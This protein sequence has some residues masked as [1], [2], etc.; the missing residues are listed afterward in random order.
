MSTTSVY[1]TYRATLKKARSAAS[2]GRT[3]ERKQRALKVA[4]DRHHLPISQVKQIVRDM[5]AV[6]N[7]THEHTAEYQAKLDFQI[8]AR[9]LKKEANGA[10]QSSFHSEYTDEQR[11]EHEE[12]VP[13]DTLTPEI[14]VHPYE[15]E[16]YGNAV[17]VFVC[18]MCYDV[19]TEDV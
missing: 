19:L 6:N 3:S 16:M 10:C 17:P 12:T 14:R 15:M 5:D 9:A 7:I 18:G 4:A 2:G 13:W 11:A 1:N 8:A